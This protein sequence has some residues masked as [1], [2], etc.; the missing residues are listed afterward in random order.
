MIGK[1]TWTGHVTCND[2]SKQVAEIEWGWARKTLNDM[3]WR[4]R[5]RVWRCPECHKKHNA[6]SYS[7]SVA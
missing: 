7:N 4:N 1:V 5:R 3:G 2:C 6:V